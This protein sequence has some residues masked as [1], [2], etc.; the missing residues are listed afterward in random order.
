MIARKTCRE[1]KDDKKSKSDLVSNIGT[2]LVFLLQSDDIKGAVKK[3]DGL[4]LNT[5]PD[6]NDMGVDSMENFFYDFGLYC[7]W[8]RETNTLQ[9]S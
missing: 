4:Y 7:L 6:P 3:I 9:Q 5:P 1:A 8:G 2:I